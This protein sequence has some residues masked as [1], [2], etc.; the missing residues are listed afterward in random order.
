MRTGKVGRK[1]IKVKSNNRSPLIKKCNLE[2]VLQSSRNSKSSLLWKLCLHKCWP[3]FWYKLSKVVY[4]VFVDNMK[5]LLFLLLL[6]IKPNF[7]RLMS[8]NFNTVNCLRTDIKIKKA[9]SILQAE[10]C[11]SWKLQVDYFSSYITNFFL[12]NETVI[13]V[14]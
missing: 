5:M 1:L 9:V 8:P 4:A 10:K 7:A 2:H 13:S 6:S 12:V 3:K 11:H 14:K